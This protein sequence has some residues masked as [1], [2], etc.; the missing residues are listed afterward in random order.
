MGPIRDQA[1]LDGKITQRIEPRKAMP[2]SY[3]QDDLTMLNSNRVGRNDQAAVR[4]PH[5]LRNAA[6]ALGGTGPPRGNQIDLEPGRSAL[7][8]AQEA[9]VS[10][11]FRMYQECDTAN[12]GRDFIKYLEP[13]AGYRGL[14][15]RKPGKVPAGMCHICNEPAADGIADEHKYNWYS[16][17]FPLHNFGNKIRARYDQLRCHTDKLFGKST[18]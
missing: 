6:L 5:E 3:S 10:R 4:L 9:N 14:E 13:F 8:R 18:G 17:R 12:V 15:N 7:G 11:R 1:P 2:R 16:T